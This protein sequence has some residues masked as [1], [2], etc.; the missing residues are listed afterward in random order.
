MNNLNIIKIVTVELLIMILIASCST[1]QPIKSIANHIVSQHTDRG[2][3]MVLEAIS[4]EEGQANLLPTS[5]KQLIEFTK[6]IQ[7]AGDKVVLI[8]GYSDNIGDPNEN[9]DL[10]KQRAEA[11]RNAL[12]ARGIK[13]N[14]LI[15]DGFGHSRPVAS[16]RTEEGRRKNRRVEIVIINEKAE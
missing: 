14:R 5:E 13:T 7:N 6:I 4:F 1:A 8:E 2:L 9:L 15:A 3:L 12:I 10:S 11:V 16:N